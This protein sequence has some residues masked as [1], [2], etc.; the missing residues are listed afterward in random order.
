M[1][2]SKGI[3]F[4]IPKPIRSHFMIDMRMVCVHEIDPNSVN[5]HNILDDALGS[6]TTYDMNLG[7]SHEY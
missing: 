1:P 5:L 2:S 7:E 4:P 3:S 6:L